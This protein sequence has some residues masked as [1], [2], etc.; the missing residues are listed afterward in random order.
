M[1]GA[2]NTTSRGDGTEPNCTG[3]WTATSTTVFG[4][5]VELRYNSTTQCA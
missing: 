5:T 3:A 1:A 2:E 4:R